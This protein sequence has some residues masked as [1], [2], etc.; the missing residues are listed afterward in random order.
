MNGIKLI[1]MNEL[2]KTLCLGILVYCCMTSNSVAS[3]FVIDSENSSTYYNINAFLNYYEDFQNKESIESIIENKQWSKNNT[4]EV[5]N[6]GFVDYPVWIYFSAKLDHGSNRQFNLVVPYPLL[7]YA[8]VFLIS[9]EDNSILWSATLDTA[10]KDEGALR[11]HQINFALPDVKESSFSIYLKVSSHTSL[12]V[13]LEIWPRDQLIVRLN[14]ET[15]IWGG[16]F[17]IIIALMLYNSFLVMSMRDATYAFY[18]LTLLSVLVLNLSILGFGRCYIWKEAS[19]TEYTLSI[20]AASISFFQLC[21]CISFLKAENIKPIIRYAIRFVAVMA[22][23]VAIYAFYAPEHGAIAVTWVA[24][25]TVSVVMTAGVSSLLSGQVIARYFV[26][27]TTSFAIGAALYLANVISILPSSLLTN[28]SFQVGSVL[29]VFLYS[30]AL[31]HRIKEERRQKLLVMKEMEL[32]QRTIVQVQNQ[33]LDQALHDPETRKPNEYLFIN[34]VN[35]QINSEKGADAFYIVLMCFS[36]IKQISSSMG[37]RLSEEVFES[38]IT[39]LESELGKDDQIIPIEISTNSYVAVIEFGN[40]AFICKTGVGF[41]PVNE[42]VGDLIQLYDSALRIGETSIR[43]DAYCGIASYPKHGD[44]ADLLLQHAGAARDYGIRTSE[45]LTVYSSEIDIFGR[46][47]LA[48]VGGILHAVKENELQIYLQPQFD[49][50][51]LTLVGAEVLLRWSSDKFGMVSPAEFIEVAEE[52]GLMSK[53]TYYLIDQAFSFLGGLYGLSLPIKLSLNLSVQNLTEMKLVADVIAMAE[54]HRVNLS[55]VVFEVTETCMSKNMQTVGQTLNQLAE[56]GCHISLD[57]Y[58]TG[59]SSLAYLSQLPINEL[60]IDRAFVSQM[61]RHESDYRI[62]ENTVKLAKA[63]QIRTVAEGVENQQTF[64]SLMKLGC[65][66]VQGYYFAKP[67][68]VSQFKE[69]I[70]RRAS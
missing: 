18:V 54:Y 9:N 17:G 36:Q 57:D 6:F 61:M 68:P 11:S 44:R 37:R 65:N 1:L 69:W 67:M 7:Q 64:D 47:R 42:Y 28:Y 45:F 49:C 12:Q 53:I 41:R 52:S 30:F 16:Y 4:G 27:A 19:I 29:E 3:E 14:I 48:L 31:A 39:R 20:S 24:V 62:V 22:L 51:T 46:R 13:P 58:G 50:S 59:Y 55:D 32:A 34:R 8:E 33:A 70:L 40:L 43:L 15:L 21:F 38:V 10:L 66:R 5:L 26:I 63:L 23:F 2:T 60:K 25:L 56:A 35:E